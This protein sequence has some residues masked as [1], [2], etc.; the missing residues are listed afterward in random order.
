MLPYPAHV[1]MPPASPSTG[2]STF[3]S[4]PYEG[5]TPASPSTR[6]YSGSGRRAEIWHRRLRGRNAQRRDLEEHAHVA[7][8]VERVLVDAQIE[9]RQ[10][11]N[12]LVGA[13]LGLADHRAAHFQPAGG[14]VGIDGQDRHR[15]SARHVAVFLA[16]F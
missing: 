14:V 10:R 16:A 7:C 13:L 4:E 5:P 11:I 2:A 6:Q 8:L 1:A 15:R 9:P 12:V 3:L